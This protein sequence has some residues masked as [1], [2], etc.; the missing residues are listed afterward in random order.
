MKFTVVIP[1]YLGPYR[2]AAANRPEK[3]A[4]AIN[5][6]LNQTFKDF[7]IIVVADGCEQTMDI[8]KDLPVRSFLIEKQKEWTGQ[9]NKGLDEAKGEF[10]AYLDVDDLFG[11]NHLENI[12]KGLNGYDWVWFNDI[13]YSP[14]LEQWY[15]NP[16]DIMR[17]GSH[18]TSNICH[19]A[20]LP[21][22]WVHKGYAH[23]YY[24]I[25]ALKQNMNYTKIHGGEYYVCHIPN[26]NIGKGYDL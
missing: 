25:K 7:E 11:V 3:L 1:S 21:Y 10:I 13:R 4:R 9:R 26:S 19:K 15:E 18:G 23:D 12:S 16:C 24:F 22:R 20:S 14:K 8:V 6:V 5:S 2:T 17:I